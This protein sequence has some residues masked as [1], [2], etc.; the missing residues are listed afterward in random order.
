MRLTLALFAALTLCAQTLPPN[1]SG[2]SM[3]HIHLNASDVP[4]AKHF[5]A[6]LLGGTPVKLGAN[7]GVKVPG[8]IILLKAAKPSDGTAGSVVN[9]I[10][11]LVKDLAAYQERL[12]TEK[13]VYDPSSSHND[14]QLTFVGPDGVRVEL[15]RD[16]AL[17]TPVAFHH[18]H[19]YVLPVPEIQAW[20]AKTF[21]AVPGKR[22][23][24]DAGDVPGANLTFSKSDKALAPTKGRS[25]DHIGFEVANLEEF[26][27]KL[28]AQGVKFDTP[29]RKVPTLGISLAFFTDPWGTYIELTEGL[30]KL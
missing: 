14:K 10:G 4:A 15:T 3:G 6:D 26:C 24:F 18:I 11:L 20:Y 8:A 22:G 23:P 17:A 30:N 12:A 7:E 5:W 9:H 13:Y 27:R 19:F 1:A 16:P 21:G 25:L 28:E 2:V 29:Y